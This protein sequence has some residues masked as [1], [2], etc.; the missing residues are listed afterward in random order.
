M[1]RR[2]LPPAYYDR[3]GNPLD[4]V[5]VWDRLHEDLAYRT[6]G[7]T[8][9][10]TVT[11]RTLWHGLDTDLRGPPVRELFGTARIDERG[12]IKE[13]ETYSNEASA[14]AGHHR[15]VLVASRKH[16]SSS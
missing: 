2:K 1:K 15:H 4:D 6:V 14:V 11:I 3:A 10:G 12:G 5:L 13:L 16:Q 9:V 7:E 8:V